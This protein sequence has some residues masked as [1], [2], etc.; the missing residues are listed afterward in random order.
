MARRGW[1][2]YHHRAERRGAMA[3]VDGSTFAHVDA[4]ALTTPAVVISVAGHCYSC[5]H[6][7]T[8]YI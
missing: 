7:S 4:C 5:I 6:I 1:F 2:G 3:V 8:S